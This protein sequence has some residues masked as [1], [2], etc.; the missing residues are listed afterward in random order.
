MLCDR[1]HCLVLNLIILHYYCVIL[2]RYLPR[3]ENAIFNQLQII[4]A[5]K[6]CAL[7]TKFNIC[8]HFYTPF[9]IE[10]KLKYQNYF[11]I[12]IC[13]YNYLECFLVYCNIS[14]IQTCLTLIFHSYTIL[15]KISGPLVINYIRQNHF[16][17]KVAI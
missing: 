6:V 10:L 7:G 12:L 9:V 4:V 15:S 8:M 2:M 11:S 17:I 13:I 16:A 5:K 3:L 1:V 14:K